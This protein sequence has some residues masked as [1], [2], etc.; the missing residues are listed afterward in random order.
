MKQS[1]VNLQVLLNELSENKINL[2]V[3]EQVI[4]VGGTGSGESSGSGHSDRSVG[5]SSNP[6]L[7]LGNGK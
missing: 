7:H 3:D 6:G 1:N 5:S 2:V 4:M